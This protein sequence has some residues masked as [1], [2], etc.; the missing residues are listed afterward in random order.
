[1]EEL[2][3]SVFKMIHNMPKPSK[4]ASKAP[5]SQ[6]KSG[7]IVSSPNLL[8]LTSGQQHLVAA[9]QIGST[10]TLHTAGKKHPAPEKVSPSKSTENIESRMQQSYMD[11]N[12]VDLKEKPIYQNTVLANGELSKI[13]T[14]K[15]KKIPPKRPPPPKVLPQKYQN[16]VYA[17]LQRSNSDSQ[18]LGTARV[19]ANFNN[20]KL[21]K[22]TS[23]T[24]EGLNLYMNQVTSTNN[25]EEMFYCNQYDG[26]MSEFIRKT[27]ISMTGHDDDIDENGYVMMSLD[28]S[29]TS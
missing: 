18:T 11:V 26:T 22:C 6:T 17:N 2:C 20:G 27:Y 15:Q 9:T 29:L 7:K 21:D 16:R 25:L 4:K 14:G 23:K 10:S 8:Q 24:T 12:S 5:I 1:M 3:N 28:Q 13:T 19:Y